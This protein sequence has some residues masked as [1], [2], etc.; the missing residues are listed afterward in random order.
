MRMRPARSLER[1]NSMPISWDWATTMIWSVGRKSATAAMTMRRRVVMYPTMWLVTKTWTS[2]ADG[3]TSRSTARYG[4]RVP[5]WRDGLRIGMATGSISSR[6]AIPGW[7]TNHGGLL[8]S[9][10][11]VGSQLAASGVGCRAGREL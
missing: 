4:F 11:A 2:M 8:H 6:G 10:T 5:R 1:T 3:A 7:M 9:T